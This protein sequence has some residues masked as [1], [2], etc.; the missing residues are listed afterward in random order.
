MTDTS[1]PF[2]SYPFD[3]YPFDIGAC[4]SPAYV[5]DNALLRR[6]LERL[7]EVQEASGAKILLAL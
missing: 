7:G 4:P 6:N 1:Y 3:A 5:V 2:D